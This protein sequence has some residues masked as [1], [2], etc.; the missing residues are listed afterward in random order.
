MTI[1]QLKAAGLV[2]TADRLPPPLPYVYRF[3]FPTGRR[4]QRCRVLARGR[5]PGPR[6]LLLEFADGF[7]LVSTWR[8][9]RK[10]G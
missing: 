9:V 2:T 8:S 5:G 3:T 4:G 1:Q 10:E 7:R 6:N